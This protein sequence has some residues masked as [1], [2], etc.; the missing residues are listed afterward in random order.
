MQKFFDVV[1]RKTLLLLLLLL[2][3]ILREEKHLSVKNLRRLQPSTYH[4]QPENVCHG[5]AGIKH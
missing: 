4:V 3:L 5:A 1:P 2:L